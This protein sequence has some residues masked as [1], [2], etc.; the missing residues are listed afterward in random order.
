MKDN[1]VEGPFPPLGGMPEGQGGKGQDARSANN[2]TQG[3]T[4]VWGQ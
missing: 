1:S 3:E 4:A 2:P